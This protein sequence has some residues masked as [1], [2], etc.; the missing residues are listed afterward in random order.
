M[1]TLSVITHVMCVFAHKEGSTGLYKFASVCAMTNTEGK[2]S[3]KSLLM[4][5]VTAD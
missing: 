2:K 5:A 4:N 3:L 1:S